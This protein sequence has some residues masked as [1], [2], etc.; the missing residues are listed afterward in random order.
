[1]S[2]LWWFP[3]GYISLG[4]YGL[5]YGSLGN[6]NWGMRGC[7]ECDDRD[8]ARTRRTLECRV[9]YAHGYDRRV[10][11]RRLLSGGKTRNS[12]NVSAASDFGALASEFNPRCRAF[13]YAPAHLVVHP[14]GSVSGALGDATAKSRSTPDDFVLVRQQ[15]VR[16]THR[17]GANALSCRRTDS[18][19]KPSQRGDFLPLRGVCRSVFVLFFRRGLRSMESLGPGRLLEADPNPIFFKRP[20]SV[21]SGSVDPNVGDDWNFRPANSPTFALP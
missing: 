17:R 9:R 14:A 7:P 16:S 15:L 3:L 12:A 6:V 4:N 13:A 10:G 1:M 20:G 2:L 21:N 11:V 8:L 18:L 19:H 5:G